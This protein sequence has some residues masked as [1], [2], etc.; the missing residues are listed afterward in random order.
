MISYLIKE[1]T[2]K[3]TLVPRDLSKEGMEEYTLIIHFYVYNSYFSH[4]IIDRFPR[5]YSNEKV[6]NKNLGANKN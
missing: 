2:S 5:I 1:C 3:F 4:R 6:Q